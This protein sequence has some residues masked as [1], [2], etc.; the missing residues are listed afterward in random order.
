MIAPVWIRASAVLL[1]IFGFTATA[2]ASPMVSD[3]VALPS[4]LPAS[5]ASSLFSGNNKPTAL[6]DQLNAGLFSQVPSGWTQVGSSDDSGGGPFTGNS[7]GTSGTLTFDSLVNGPFVI[8]LKAGD[9]YAAYFFDSSFAGVTGVNFST[10]GFPLNPAGNPPGLSHATL[11][12]AST[13]TTTTT[14]T[15]NDPTTTTN[16]TSIL[17]NPATTTTETS[18]TNVITATGGVVPEPAT[19]ALWGLLGGGMA[20]FGRRR[21][22]ARAAGRSAD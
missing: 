6:L 9:D 16:S 4:N 14:T 1:S 20:L 10:G 21:K 15:T 5:D 13:G 8:A 18:A 12:V 7:N 19:L 22:L 2:A 17:T 11:Y 3:V